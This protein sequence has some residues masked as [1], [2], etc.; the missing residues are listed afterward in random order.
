MRGFF[1]KYSKL[2]VIVNIAFAL[3]IGVSV[4][5]VIKNVNDIN[6][7]K[8]YLEQ[9]GDSSS[10]NQSSNNNQQATAA[11]TTVDP[12]ITELENE[13]K[14]KEETLERVKTIKNDLDTLGTKFVEGITTFDSNTYDDEIMQKLKPFVTDSCYA[15]AEEM[16]RN[17]SV[18]PSGFEVLNIVYCDLDT[19][20]PK[21]IFYCNY[22]TVF[23]ELS[24][25]I[26]IL[27]FIEDKD[28]E[29]GYSVSDFDTNI[30]Y[31]TAVG[32]YDRVRGK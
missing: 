24:D 17:T 15:K 26:F 22:S 4:F 5:S 10:D 31:S 21:A 7:L 28:S 3:A 12:E 20:E 1:Q 6:I 19:D 29:Y 8:P 14:E 23:N 30:S 2:I 32:F 27:T 16:C 25:N 13:V 9:Y 11:P 18:L